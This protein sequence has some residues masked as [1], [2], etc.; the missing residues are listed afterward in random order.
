VADLSEFEE[1]MRAIRDRVMPAAAEPLTPK[2]KAVLESE[3][4]TERRWRDQTRRHDWQDRGIPAALFDLLQYPKL[5]AA[6]MATER[7]MKGPEKFLVM[8]GNKGVGKTIAAL[9]AVG[10]YAGE[11]VAAESLTTQSRYNAEFWDDLKLTPVLAIDELSAEPKSLKD[12]GWFES[13]LLALLSFRDLSNRK[14]IITANINRA[15]FKARYG[16]GAME[17]LWD[18]IVGSNQLEEIA[19]ESLRGREPGEEG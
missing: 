6:F 16:T 19:G 1:R 12:D 13:K 4:E 10:N 5:T 14:T 7:F 15:T 3:E 17:R 8:L 18:R 2:A 9:W 11:F